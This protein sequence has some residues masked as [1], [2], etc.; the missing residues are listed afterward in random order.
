[1]NTQ[2]FPSAEIAASTAVGSAANAGVLAQGT[3]ASETL[4]LFRHSKRQLRI[5]LY[6]LLMAA[7]VFCIFGCFA[8]GALVRF[9]DLHELTWLRMSLPRRRCSLALRCTMAPTRSKP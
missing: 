8:F 3:V 2:T 6:S 5:N 7:D 4:P 1:M 9:G